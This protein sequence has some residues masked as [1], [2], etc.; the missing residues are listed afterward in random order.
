MSFTPLAGRGMIGGALGRGY[1]RAAAEV[2]WKDPFALAIGFHVEMD[3]DGST[4]R[5]VK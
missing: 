3:T 4:G 2:P 1:R 5:F